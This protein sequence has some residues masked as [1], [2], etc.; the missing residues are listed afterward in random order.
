MPRPEI[1]DEPESAPDPKVVAETV[2]EPRSE[3]VEETLP[4]ASPETSAERP[5]AAQDDERV[6]QGPN[7]EEMYGVP[8]TDFDPEDAEHQLITDLT[9]S[10]REETYSGRTTTNKSRCV[11]SE[12]P[13]QQMIIQQ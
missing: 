3:I 8:N 6:F 13:G 1:V 5:G 11:S 12:K 9:F 10:A 7:G 2:P 4:D